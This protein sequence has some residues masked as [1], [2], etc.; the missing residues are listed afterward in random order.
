MRQLG[1]LYITVAVLMAPLLF[2]CVSFAAPKSLLWDYWLPNNP[3]SIEKVDHSP[4]DLFLRTYIVQG[5]DSINRVAYGKVS[6]ADHKALKNYITGLSHIHVLKLNR[7]EQQAY[8]INL[9][10]ALTIDVILDHY[11]VKSIRDI[12]ISPGWFSDGPW[13]E[14]LL[15]V[16]GVEIT[17]DDIEHRILRPIWK[18]PRIHYAV[19]CAAIDCPNL[20]IEAFTAENTEK[21]LDKGAR[22][23]INHKRGVTTKDKKLKVSSI[24]KWFISDFGVNDE[25]VINHLKEH[26]NP[27]LRIKLE[28]MKGISGHDYDW[29]LNDAEGKK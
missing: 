17:I 14:K 4:W 23:Y 25:G 3:E 15:R 21:L 11:P 5:E 28:G 18:D 9:Y 10:N 8:W 12:D 16:E 19:N 27:E 20:Q 26:A 13:G 7:A 6:K 24:Y 22:E 2:H 29:A 1:R